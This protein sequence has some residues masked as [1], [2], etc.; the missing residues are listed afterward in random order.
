MLWLWHSLINFSID[1]WVYRLVILSKLIRSV[2]VQKFFHLCPVNLASKVL[3]VNTLLTIPLRSCKSPGGN[4]KTSVLTSILLSCKQLIPAI[5]IPVV[6]EQSEQA[7]RIVSA[8]VFRWDA[9]LRD[10][11]CFHLL[12][13]STVYYRGVCVLRTFFHYRI[14]TFSELEKSIAKANV[15]K[16]FKYFCCK[17]GKRFFP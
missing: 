16:M 5:Y 15:M 10:T 9:A 12:I 4:R 8:A 13:G 6:S 17:N 14:S 1:L 3:I 7:Q 2:T 11:T